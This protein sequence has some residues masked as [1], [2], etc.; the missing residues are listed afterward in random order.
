MSIRSFSG[1]EPFKMMKTVDKVVDLDPSEVDEIV[2]AD[3]ILGGLIADPDLA[4]ADTT[5]DLM[6]FPKDG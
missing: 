5:K 1:N 2:F 6:R 4:I 3:D